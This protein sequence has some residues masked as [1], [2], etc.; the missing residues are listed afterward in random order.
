MAG[1]PPGRVVGL[2]YLEGTETHLADVCSG[3]AT[4]C[5]ASTD[6]TVRAWDVQKVHWQWGPFVPTVSVFLQ[7]FLTLTAE[8]MNF[9]CGSIHII[10]GQTMFFIEKLVV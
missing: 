7:Q 8:I 10:L 1:G 3:K 6:G 5:T 4:I 9:L 2:G